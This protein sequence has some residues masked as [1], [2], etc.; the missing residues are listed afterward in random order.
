MNQIHLKPPQVLKI[1]ILGAARIAPKAICIPALALD[2]QLV[3]VAARDLSR[4]KTFASQWGIKKSYGSYQE[5]INDSEVDVIYNALPNGVHAMW[6]IKALEGKKHVISEKPFASNAEEARQVA[7]IA[8]K[9]GKVIIEAFHNFY[10]PVNQRA[11]AVVKSGEIGEMLSITSVLKI[12][13][14]P[15]SDIRWQ[16]DLGGGANMDVG[17]YNA[18]IQRHFG[19]ALFGVEPK[20]ISATAIQRSPDLDESMNA[21]LV[22]HNGAQGHMISSMNAESLENTLTV[23]GNKG[24]VFIPSFVLPGQDDRIIITT[25]SDTRTEF[26]GRI[27]SYIWQLQAFAEAVRTDGAIATDIEDAIKNAE[28]LDAIYEASGLKPRERYTG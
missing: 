13:A 4:A 26:L 2:H 8:K 24:S 25:D 16:L 22:H 7:R 6:N 10:S 17:C 27:S 12:V 18:H 1:G 23:I 19:L 28:F 3:A 20:L 14:P 9:S 5:L 21:E 15:T 11:I